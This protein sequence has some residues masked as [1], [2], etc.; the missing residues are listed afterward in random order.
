MI[1]VI[2]FHQTVISFP[3]QLYFNVGQCDLFNN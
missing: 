1:V 2:T 3:L